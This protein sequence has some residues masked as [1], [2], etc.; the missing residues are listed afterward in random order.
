[1]T[2]ADSLDVFLRAPIVPAPVTSCIAS[3]SSNV[4]SS[5]RSSD[6]ISSNFNNTTNDNEPN[7]QNSQDNQK[8]EFDLSSSLVQALTLNTVAPPLPP[9][10]SRLNTINKQPAIVPHNT[11]SDI[12]V[13]DNLDLL[14]EP[15]DIKSSFPNKT[16]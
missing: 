3:T 4:N 12:P 1:M 16:S 7:E 10:V 14:I 13:T 8:E 9:R 6:N 15:F 2:T 5:A 11:N